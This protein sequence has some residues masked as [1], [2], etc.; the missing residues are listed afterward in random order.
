VDV[1]GLAKNVQVI[2]GLGLGLDEKA[3]DA[4]GRWQF[5]PG[6]SNGVPVPILAKIEINFRLL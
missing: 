5:K 3:V 1:D 2:Q 4:V 6:E